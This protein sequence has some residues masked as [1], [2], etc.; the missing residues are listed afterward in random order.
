MED[1]T[2]HDRTEKPVV[3]R[4]ANHERSMLNEVDIDF[5]IPGLPHSVVKQ[6]D[7]YR[8]RELVKKIENHP[9]RHALHRDLQQNKAYNPFCE[10]YKKMI[11]G[12]GNVELFE[13]FE[14]APKTQRKECLLYWNLGIIY[15]TCGHL[16]KERAANRGVIQ[17]T[18][19]LLS[20]P[21]FFLLFLIFLFIFALT[22]HKCQ[23]GKKA[24]LLFLFLPIFK[25]AFLFIL[26]LP[27][28]KESVSF[29]FYF[30]LFFKKAFLLF[31]DFCPFF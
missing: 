22:F 31:F 16:L 2:N 24:F 26:F 5:R 25:K 11:K 12:M 23:I 19:D 14:T 10:K 3:C 7:N 29:Y 30:C 1:D 15:C 13:L 6:A 8:V 18:L 9:Y 20:I 28:F 4:D 27:F 21:P 17:Y